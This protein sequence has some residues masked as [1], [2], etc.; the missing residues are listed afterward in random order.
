MRTIPVGDE[1]GL[2]GRIRETESAEPSRTY[3][4]SEYSANPRRRP[5]GP[6][7]RRHAK[8]G[9]R[10][11]RNKCQPG[12]TLRRMP[13]TVWRRHR[14]K[15][16]AGPVTAPGHEKIPLAI[17]TRERSF[18]LA[19][20]KGGLLTGAAKMPCCEKSRS[21]TFSFTGTRSK[22]RCPKPN[23]PTENQRNSHC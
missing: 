2:M 9:M 23:D 1:P 21:Q 22:E 10:N 18:G 14:N 17:G 15:P 4:S 11:I 13:S 20:R 12:E 3:N 8:V 5:S 6:S 7:P 16:D 19:D